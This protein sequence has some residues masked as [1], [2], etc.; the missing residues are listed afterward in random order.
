VF[1]LCS[2]LLR[3][4]VLE[5]ELIFK[6][7]IILYFATSVLKLQHVITPNYFSFCT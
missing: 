4:I 2:F 3:S 1:N 6:L 5:L 7:L